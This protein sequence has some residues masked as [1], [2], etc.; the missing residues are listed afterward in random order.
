[1]KKYILKKRESKKCEDIKRI[2][3]IRKETII[4]FLI[5]IRNYV[6]VI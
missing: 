2:A 1:M 4:E 3:F 5:P 6:S